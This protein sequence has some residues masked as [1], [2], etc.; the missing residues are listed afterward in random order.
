MTPHRVLLLFKFVGVMLYGGGLVASAVSAD[1]QARRRAVHRVASPGLMLT[2][3][4]GYL[5]TLQ[6]QV[7]LGELW[8]LSGLALSFCSQIALVR[9][10]SRHSA[11][12]RL[13]TLVAA[14]CL[15][16]ALCAMIFRPTWRGVAP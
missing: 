10:V 2:W 3:V 7:A 15:L 9:S 4:T 6:V 1:P 12:L 16:G 8:V 14:L 5:L 13:S 11:S